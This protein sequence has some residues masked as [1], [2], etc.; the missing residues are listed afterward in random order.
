MYQEPRLK[1]EWEGAYIL[2]R[3]NT[4]SLMLNSVIPYRGAFFYFKVRRDYQ[5][6]LSISISKGKETYK[7]SLSNNE[8]TR[9]YPAL[10]S[11][12]AVVQIVVWRNVLSGGPGPS[13]L[14]R[15]AREGESPVVPGPYR[16]TRLC[17]LVG[18]FWNAT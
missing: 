1:V 10:E 7:D 18:L 5:L 2:M 11:S 14:E 4:I 17:L 3:W 6:I 13:P 15:G 12:G 9:N 16:T 8:R